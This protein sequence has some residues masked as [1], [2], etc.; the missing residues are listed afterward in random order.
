MDLTDFICQENRNTG[1]Q[2]L[3]SSSVTI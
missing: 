3:L 2:Q 1:S